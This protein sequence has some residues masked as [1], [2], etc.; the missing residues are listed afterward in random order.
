MVARAT[1]IAT[2]IRFDPT[3]IVLIIDRV[4]ITTYEDSL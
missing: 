2:T 3:Y 1:T 4:I